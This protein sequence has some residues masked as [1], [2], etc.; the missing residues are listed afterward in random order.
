[1]GPRHAILYNND[2]LVEVDGRIPRD[3]VCNEQEAVPK[4]NKY[5]QDVY[6]NNKNRNC[7]RLN[8]SITTDLLINKCKDS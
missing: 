6:V 1:M 5:K 8:I 3:V 2:L 4:L 7:L